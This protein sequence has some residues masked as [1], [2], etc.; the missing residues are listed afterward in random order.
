MVKFWT[1]EEIDILLRY[2]VSM[3]S[4]KIQKLYLSHRTINSIQMKAL[5]LGLKSGYQ[6]NRSTIDKVCSWCQVIFQ[7]KTSIAK[8]CSTA[9]RAKEFYYRKIKQDPERWNQLLKSASKSRHKRR[10]LIVRK[11]RLKFANDEEY[12]TRCRE[13]T[14][15]SRIRKPQKQNWRRHG[16]K[17]RSSNRNVNVQI[18]RSI[19]DYYGEDPCV[20]CGKHRELTLEHIIPLIDNGTNEFGNLVLACRSCNSAKNDKSLLEFLIYKREIGSPLC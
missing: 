12:R 13:I 5:E 14:A 19:F 18:L 2:Y 7:A 3:T 8:F 20:Y 16:I 10:D 17:R 6:T 9:C 4:I 11:H 1:Q 15:Q